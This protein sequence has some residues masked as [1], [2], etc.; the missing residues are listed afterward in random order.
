M[1]AG[2]TLFFIASSGLWALGVADSDGDG[3]VDIEDSCPI[4]PNPGQADFDED[5][6]GDACD[7]DDDDDG[8]PDSFENAHGLNPLNP[9]D[10][11]TD[12]DGDGFTNLFEYLTGTDPSDPTSFNAGPRLVPILQ[13][14]LDD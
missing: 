1:N 7:P 12:L 14:V 11:S 6:A 9:A 13:M 8:M 5:G 4:N 10:A 2:G 3:I